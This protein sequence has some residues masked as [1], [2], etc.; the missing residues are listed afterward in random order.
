MRKSTKLMAGLGVVAG[1]G[2]ALAPLATFAAT[3][4]TAGSDTLR[5]TVNSDC[6]LHQE[7]NAE[8]K[9]NGLFV[10]DEAVSANTPVAVTLS[11]DTPDEGTPVDAIS[12]DCTLNSMVSVYAATAGLT[13]PTG[14]TPITNIVGNYTATSLWSLQNSG[15]VSI[16]NTAT[17][18]GTGT[19]DNGTVENGLTL[20]R[21]NYNVTPNANQ[22]PG[23]YEG[24]V[25]YTWAIAANN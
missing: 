16:G 8:V 17:L 12:F 6:A 15:A 14:S 5:L 23:T 25:N 9:F 19:M 2:V 21:T 7:S 4:G 24:T 18:I 10:N 13:G 3:N 11:K 1:L 20:T 22:K